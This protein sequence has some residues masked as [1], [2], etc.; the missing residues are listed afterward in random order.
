[1]SCVCL[2]VYEGLVSVRRCMHAR[3]TLAAATYGLSDILRL[4]KPEFAES[5]PTASWEQTFFF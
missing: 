1:M 4:D 5:I 2:S 3:I